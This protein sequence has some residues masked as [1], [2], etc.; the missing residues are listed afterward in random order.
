LS[1]NHNRSP[2]LD[3]PNAS[4]QASSCRSQKGSCRPTSQHESNPFLGCGLFQ[5]LQESYYEIQYPKIAK[6]VPWLTLVKFDVDVESSELT[7]ALAV[8][9]ISLRSFGNSLFFCFQRI[10]DFE[11]LVRFANEECSELVVEVSTVSEM[12]VTCTPACRSSSKANTSKRRLSAKRAIC[13]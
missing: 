6:I 7:R 10:K 11:F 9:K 1:R 3:Y 5:T 12:L 4:L 8:L 2:H 13:I